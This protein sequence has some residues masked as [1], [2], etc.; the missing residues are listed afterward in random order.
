MNGSSLFGGESFGTLYESGAIFKINTLS[1]AGVVVNATGE[2]GFFSIQDSTGGNN[3]IDMTVDGK[4]MTLNTNSFYQTFGG[5]TGGSSGD[6][7]GITYS[8]SLKVEITSFTS[9]TVT[10]R[11]FS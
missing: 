5:A 6:V 4:L 3:T 2:K 9:G 11:R 8:S 1:T 7:R 10:V